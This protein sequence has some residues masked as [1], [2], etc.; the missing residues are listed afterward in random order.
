[1]TP[2]FQQKFPPREKPSLTEVGRLSW[3]H[4]GGARA[5]ATGLAL[6]D[7]VFDLLPFRQIVKAL[8]GHR[9]VVKEDVLSGFRLDES[10]SFV[11]D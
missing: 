1:M 9:G 11:V 4:G 5:F 10:E 8:V 3:G 6:L 7:F 2:K